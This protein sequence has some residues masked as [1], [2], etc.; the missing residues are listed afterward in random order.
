MT[1]R[2][3]DTSHRSGVLDH[4]P[5]PEQH[6][7]GWRW[8]K[9]P[10]LG[11]WSPFKAITIMVALLVGALAVYPLLRVLFGLFVSN[12]HLDLTSIKAAVEMP[13]FAQLLI[14]SVIVVGASGI[15]ALCLGSVMAWLNERTDARFGILTDAIPLVP[16]LVSPIAGVI[17]W[18]LMLSPQVGFGNHL[19]RY[20]L[21]TIGVHLASGPF[22]VYS[23]AGLIAIY[24][25]YQLPYVFMIVSA[26]LR[27][28]DSS[29]EEQSRICG[30]GVLRT[31]VHITLPSI[32]HALAGAWLILI[33]LGFS[34]YAIPAVIA[35]NAHADILSVA[36]V[37][38]MIANFPPKTQL[39]VGLSLFIELFV[40]IT[41]LWQIWITKR[42][43][44]A[45]LGGR[46][47]AARRIELGRW[48]WAGRAVLLGYG[49]IA[50]IPPVCG[51]TLVAL[52]GF[53][54]PSIDWGTLSLKTLKTTVF[55][56]PLTVTAF[57]N[58]LWIGLVGASLGMLIAAVVSLVV[59]R[60]LGRAGRLVDAS[61]KLPSVFPHIIIAI[62]F[63]LA[64][65]GAP[66]HLQGTT[67]IL[68]L[69]YLCLYIPQGSVLTDAGVNQI[70]HDLTNASSLCGAGT[71]RT[72][73]KIYVPLL[74]PSV[75]A[76][77]SFLFVRMVSDLTATALLAGPSND[78]IG[79]RILSILGNGS[80]GQLAS[81]S[82]VL[83]VLTIFVVTTA[84]V[85][86][87]ILG[88]W[89]GASERA[90]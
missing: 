53:W 42:G 24:T 18:V 75:I 26:A 49:A 11:E 32:R 52:R 28:L 74:V 3:E 50:I 85:M 30:V 15:F 38:S 66:F 12:G 47:S 2:T 87:R 39:A 1:Q 71:A 73:R 67:W 31:V 5:H 57:K 51:L 54:S 59:Y 61:I 65:T 48:R 36:I 46:A 77:W 41:W 79:F 19:I 14:D 62:G 63:I 23:M 64:F 56:D 40:G 81:V 55:N 7:V 8:P 29:L 70:G 16:F 43:R 9:V 27:N 20:V 90:F 37:N 82:L 84:L 17:G 4:A 6:N 13:N 80:F 89:R 83:T 34:I 72:F 68:L 78:V 35:P 33:L 21:G 22:N 86:S 69:V 76:G 10:R 58:S 45:V 44:H 25:I 88:R 60:Q